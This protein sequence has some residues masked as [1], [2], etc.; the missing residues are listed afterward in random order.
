MTNLPLVV[1]PVLE[2]FPGFAA[3][4]RVIYG[5]VGSANYPKGRFN[6]LFNGLS[7]SCFNS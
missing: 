7:R 5:A 2:G 3:F 6:V 4:S 1:Q